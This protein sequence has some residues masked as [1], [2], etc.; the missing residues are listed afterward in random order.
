MS[1]LPFPIQV[2]PNAYLPADQGLVAWNYDPALIVNAFTPTAGSIYFNSFVVRSNVSVSKLYYIVSSAAVTP[3]AGQNWFGL[4]Q[5]AGA[6][7]T[8]LAQVAADALITTPGTVIGSITPQSLVPGIYYSAM[9][10]NCVTSPQ[11]RQSGSTGGGVNA[12]L[13]VAASRSFVNGTVQTTLPG[14]IVLANNTAQQSFW[15]GL[16]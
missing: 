15:V 8:L 2:Q 12:N 7:A 11:L 13:S 1:V 5:A 9:V 4:Y 16:S 3:T 6:N 10:V 14:S